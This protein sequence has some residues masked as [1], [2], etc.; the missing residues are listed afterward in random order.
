M[1]PITLKT[2]GYLFNGVI[3]KT[4]EAWNYAKEQYNNAIYRSKLA[5]A[6]KAIVKTEKV[7][8]AKTAL[9]NLGYSF[10]RMCNLV[11]AKMELKQFINSISSLTRKEIGLKFA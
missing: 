1:K 11:K 3:Y 5:K 6:I 2:I 4:K 7:S 10:K 9:K 8:K